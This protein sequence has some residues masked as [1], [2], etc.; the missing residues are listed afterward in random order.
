MP[1]FGRN[2]LTKFV[3]KFYVIKME[4]YLTDG[5]NTYC[6]KHFNHL[7]KTGLIP[8][9]GWISCDGP[10]QDCESDTNGREQINAKY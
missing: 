3:N 7:E 9:L 1:T 10:C 8:S 4:K 6:F 2:Q 5:S